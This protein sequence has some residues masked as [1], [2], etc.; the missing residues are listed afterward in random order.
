MASNIDSLLQKA[1]I[2]KGHIAANTVDPIITQAAQTSGGL[3][4][5]LI[6]RGI[7]SEDIIL[8]V[9]ADKLGLEKVELGQIQIQKAALDKV[10]LK[11]AEY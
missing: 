5:L 10:A 2:E 9:L 11:V 8:S 7:V 1:L 3:G 4:P 6:Q